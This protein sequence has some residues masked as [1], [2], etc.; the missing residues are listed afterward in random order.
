MA[1]GALQE[2]SSV[3]STELYPP[4]FKFTYFTKGYLHY[5]N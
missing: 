3:L 2:L 5:A 4:E 1:G